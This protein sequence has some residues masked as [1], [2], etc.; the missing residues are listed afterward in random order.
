MRSILKIIIPALLSSY[1]LCWNYMNH[2]SDWNQDVC[3]TS[4]VQSPIKLSVAGL[5]SY[6]MKAK[7]SLNY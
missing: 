3:L 2:G 4:T 5:S 7:L 1:C 6:N